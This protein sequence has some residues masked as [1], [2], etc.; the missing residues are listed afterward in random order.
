MDVV[1]WKQK[2]L[3]ICDMYELLIISL[4]FPR[5]LLW[6]SGPLPLQQFRLS[7]Q[8]P[9]HG[10]P[11]GQAVPIPPHTMSIAHLPHEAGLRKTNT[12]HWSK[13]ELS[14]CIGFAEFPLFPFSLSV[15][16]WK[17]GNNADIKIEMD[18]HIPCFTVSKLNGAPHECWW[19][20]SIVF[21]Q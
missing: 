7:L 4:G 5:F 19:H 2:L 20:N 14:S 6:W 15:V 1:S 11:R 18:S 3:Q 8:T 12:A 16:N 10:V 13:R 9:Q 17:L 21:S